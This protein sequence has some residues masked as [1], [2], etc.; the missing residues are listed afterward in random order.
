MQTFRCGTKGRQKLNNL[1]YLMVGMR[2]F[3]EDRKWDSL[4]LFFIFIFGKSSDL[5]C[6]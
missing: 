2:A 4:S 3:N 5:I 1:G 6:D